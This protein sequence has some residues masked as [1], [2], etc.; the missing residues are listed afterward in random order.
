MNK[1][2]NDSSFVP[3][4]LLGC[5]F[6]WLK[7]KINKNKQTNKNLMHLFAENTPYKMFSFWEMQVHYIVLTRNYQ[8]VLTWSLTAL[9]GT[10]DIMFIFYLLI[11]L[12]FTSILFLSPFIIKLFFKKKIISRCHGKPRLCYLLSCSSSSQTGSKGSWGQE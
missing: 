5:E 8:P 9:F 12:S 3:S 11:I 1:R 10:L 4:F 6:L 7:K 2:R